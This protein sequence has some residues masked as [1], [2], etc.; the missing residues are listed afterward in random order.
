MTRATVSVGAG[1]HIRNNHKRKKFMLTG[2]FTYTLDIKGKENQEILTAM[3]RI[4]FTTICQPT[5]LYGNTS[6][7]DEGETK[8]DEGQFSQKSLS[9]GGIICLIMLLALLA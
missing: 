5:S 7:K 9:G 2:Y 6:L 1:H 8:E 4:T 3:K